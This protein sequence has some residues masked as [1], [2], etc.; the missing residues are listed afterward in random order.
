VRELQENASAE[1]CLRV[2][3]RQG[4]S[5]RV[6][7]SL[8]D[9]WASRAGLEEVRRRSVIVGAKAAFWSCRIRI[10]RMTRFGGRSLVGRMN[11]TGKR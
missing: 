9:R 6:V 4:Q 11:G 7:C 1:A 2:E 10:G 3:M 8:P 5:T